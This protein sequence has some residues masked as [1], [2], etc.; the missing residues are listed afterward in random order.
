MPGCAT[1]PIQTITGRLLHGANAHRSQYGGGSQLI[2]K[3]CGVRSKQRPTI[4]D[5]TGGLCRDAF[6]L[7]CLGCH[8]TVIERHPIIHALVNDGLAD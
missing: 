7:A 5:L 4:L 6:V 2:A 3:A 1:T 8:V